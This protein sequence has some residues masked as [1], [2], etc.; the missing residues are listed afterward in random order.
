MVRAS[1]RKT[2]SWAR[3]KAE[4]TRKSHELRTPRPGIFVERVEVG[5]VVVVVFLLAPLQE[6][7][8]RIGHRREHDLDS[9]LE[10]VVGDQRPRPA[11]GSDNPVA[12]RKAMETKSSVST[13]SPTSVEPMV[14][15]QSHRPRG[16][17]FHLGQDKRVGELAGEVGNQAGNHDSR[18]QAQDVQVVLLE[19]PA[20]R[21]PESGRPGCRRWP[22]AACTRS[23]AR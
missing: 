11:L 14:R 9:D 10:D 7:H 3:A 16:P 20:P 5:V 19:R 2:R 22:S 13:N 17:D 21:P 23:R 6:A 8:Y 15:D 1:T 18:H 4:D 12:P